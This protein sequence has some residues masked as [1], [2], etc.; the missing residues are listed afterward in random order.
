[1]L[2]IVIPTCNEVHLGILQKA[3]SQ[4]VK[5]PSIEIICVDQNSQDGT[6]DIIKSIPAKLIVTDADTRAERMNIGIKHAT[7]DI[8]LLHHPRSFLD[9]EG[10]RCLEQLR[11]EVAWGGLTHIFDQNEHLLFKLTS[12][13]SNKIRFDKK[14]IVYLDH[15]IFFRKNLLETDPTPVPELEIFEDT[16]FSLKLRKIAPPH[17][18]LHLSTTSA[19]R[20]KKN[21]IIKQLLL[22]QMLKI[23]YYFNISTKSM[24]RIY[25]KA[26][27]LNSKNVE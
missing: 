4:L 10:I 27:N 19:Y 5:L 7:G 24:N 20:F 11:N 12:W 17:R 6:Q 22:N 21:G 26:L 18:L 3:L 25:E 2:T 1:M 14:G 13:Y 9:I 23:G 16:A 8:I 15:C